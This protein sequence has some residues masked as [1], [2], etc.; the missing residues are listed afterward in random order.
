MFV[1]WGTCAILALCLASLIGCR[2]PTPNLKPAKTAE[3]YVV[4]PQELRYETAGYPKAAYDKLI[5]PSQKAMDDKLAP[6]AM[7]TRGGGM[8]G[9]PGH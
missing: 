3:E 2:T 4:P 7:Q 5:D 9:M 1:K 8:G 6:G